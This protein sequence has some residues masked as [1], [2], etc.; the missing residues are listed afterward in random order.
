MGD[1]ARHRPGEYLSKTKRD[2]DSIMRDLD[3]WVSKHGADGYV[4]EDYRPPAY[5]KS[6]L[7]HG[8]QQVRREI[9]EFVRIL[10]LKGLNNSILEIGLGTY[11]GTHILW[12]HIF[13]RVITIESEPDRVENFRRNER[14][15]SQSVII[16]GKAEDPGTLEKV[17]ACVDYVDVLFIDGGHKYENAASDW[18]MYHNL[19]RPGG[20][21]VFHDSVCR[22]V[23]DWRI[24]KLLEDLSRGVIDNRCHTLH[25]IVYSDHVGI[26]YEEC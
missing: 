8:I 19:V 6:N 7:D 11:G 4:A 22:A 12:R 14:L 13:S 20:I 23:P 17:R 25:N 21:I 18:T 24:P 9:A 10:L 15:D 5:H 3:L 1:V 2:L 16:V 26:S